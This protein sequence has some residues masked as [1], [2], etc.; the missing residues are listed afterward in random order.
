MR[1]PLV[2]IAAVLL[3]CGL[4]AAQAV[5][6]VP[7]ATG[8]LTDQ[9]GIVEPAETARIQVMLGRYEV[10]TGRR[11]S[12]LL[13]QATPD[14]ELEQFADRVLAD[15]GVEQRDQGG[16][17]LL[18][19]A[20]GYVLIRPSSVLAGRLEGDAQN[21]ILSKWVVPAFA[22]GEAGVG[23]RQGLEQMIAVLDGKSVAEP[24]PPPVEEA[25]PSDP[26]R[27]LLDAMD[28]DVGD[29]ATEQPGQATPAAESTKESVSFDGL[30]VWIGRLPEDLRRLTAPFS[31]N[32]DAG[33][34]GWLREARG[35][36]EQLP[37]LASGLFLQMRGEQVE[38][39]FPGLSEFAVYAWAVSLGLAL[40]VLLPRGARVPALFMAAVDTG[41]FL[42]LATG[43]VALAGL[44]VLVGLLAPLLVPLLRAILRGSD[45][46][47][48]DEE[49]PIAWPT[50]QRPMHT[51]ARSAVP[52]SASAARTPA[53]SA[54]PR[55]SQVRPQPNPM[56]TSTGSGRQQID[57][58]LDRLGRIAYAEVRRL[59]LVHVGVLIAL[60]VIGFPFAIVVVLGTIVVTLYRSGA[61]YLLA[62][63][64]VKDR[65]ARE[66]LKRQLPRPSADVMQHG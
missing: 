47:E 51:P 19:S 26:E 6:P 49:A 64:F 3:L 53:R 63:V 46:S 55:T 39:P 60:C 21:Q 34:M 5:I 1:H 61:A 40:L 54:A 43:F 62:D 13:V 4:G 35:E 59:R 48:R 50:P 24:P 12:A 41:F 15:W 2:W 42:W 28:L 23:I 36:A 7:S 32:L 17:L 30:P 52:R 10:A 14:E 25:V 33:V 27:A 56:P 16:A 37:V 11:L 22:R 44:S 20:E 38:P 58:L 66:Q 65:N 8:Y 18:W 29:E 31:D 45:D 9:T 57:V